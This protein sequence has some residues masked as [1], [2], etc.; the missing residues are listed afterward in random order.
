MTQSSQNNNNDRHP[1]RAVLVWDVPTRL[2][3]W[4]L[5]ILVTACV[6]TAKIGGNWMTTHMLSGYLV[7]AL[8]LFRVVWGVVGGHHAR[9]AAFVYGPRTVLRYAARFAR[10]DAPRYLGHNPLGAWSV[11][12]MLVALALQVSTGLFASDDIFTQGPLY[13]LVS[14][15]TSKMLTRIHNINAMV[16]AGLVA[17]H[18]S[19]VM[20]Y[21]LVKG[22][23]LIKPM[24]T[25]LKMWHGEVSPCGGSL[26]AA[27]LAAGISGALAYL[28]VS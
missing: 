3:H 11:V 2:F 7:L 18:F 10:M 9:F 26:W 6:T 28:I 4:L 16:I 17:V 24:F 1:Q 15:D 12:A 22:E 19:A 21:L 23:N 25:G 27:A 13:P 20:F 5:V 14:H 8:L